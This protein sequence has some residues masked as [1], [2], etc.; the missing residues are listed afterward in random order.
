MNLKH[1]NYIFVLAVFVALAF[2]DYSQAQD[3]NVFKSEVVD[4][5]SLEK[6]RTR[7]RSFG[8]SNFDKLFKMLAEAAKKSEFET[9][10]EHQS[11]LDGLK[12]QFDAHQ[13]ALSS[14]RTATYDADKGAFSINFKDVGSENQDCVLASN[15]IFLSGLNII[16]EGLSLTNRANCQISVPIPR[17]NAPEAKQNMRFLFIGSIA[18]PFAKEER[19]FLRSGSI[20][21]KRIYFKLKEIWVVNRATGELYARIRG[22][23]TDNSFSSSNQGSRPSNV[24]I[25][26]LSAI[27]KDKTARLTK[28]ELREDATVVTGRYSKTKSAW[29]QSYM[30]VS[31]KAYIQDKETGYK[32]PIQGL[33]IDGLVVDLSSTYDTPDKREYEF[34]LFFAPLRPS[35]KLIDVIESSGWKW[36]GIT[37]QGQ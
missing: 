32:Y 36:Q 18:A 35:V 1:F 20:T 16:D 19:S 34:V 26:E 23:D 27:S 21:N 17:E 4:V 13:F 2:P 9:A 25:Q 8:G 10:S 11:R 30:T 6:D 14:D 33:M 28:I 7:L 5:S 29:S 24:V 3:F 22:E 15:T 12:G 31:R 37:I